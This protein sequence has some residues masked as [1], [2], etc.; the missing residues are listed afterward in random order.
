[1]KEKRIAFNQK[2]CNKY[3]I[4]P[5]VPALLM[6][7]VPV[8]ANLVWPALYLENRLV[9]WWAIAIGLAVEYM[10]VRRLFG[11]GVKKAILADACMN[12]A[13]TLLGIVLIPIAG[14]AWEFF[15]GIILSDLFN[16]GTFNLGT[17]VMTFFFATA[18]NAAIESLVIRM[19]FKTAVGKRGFSGL[20]MANAISVAAALGSLL[21]SWPSYERF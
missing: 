12:L 1:M 19:A 15:S 7:A 10:F 3:K 4:W 5:I 18:I 20:F 11:F 21:V 14:I 8:R 9:T 2:R 13:S 17:W 6:I 16:V